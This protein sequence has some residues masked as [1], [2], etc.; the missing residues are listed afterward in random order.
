[1]PLFGKY[2]LKNLRGEVTIIIFHF[3]NGNKIHIRNITK[4]ILRVITPWLLS[5]RILKL[6]FLTNCIKDFE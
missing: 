4:N 5:Q 6:T 1:M 3:R 2:L